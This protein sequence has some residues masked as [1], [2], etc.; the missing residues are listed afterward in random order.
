MSLVVVGW[1]EDEQ[2]DADLWRRKVKYGIGEVDGAGC[3]R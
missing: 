2:L 3:M 1:E